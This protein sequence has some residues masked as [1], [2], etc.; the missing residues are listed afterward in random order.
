MFDCHPSAE[1]LK[2]GFLEL[3]YFQDKRDDKSH[4][5]HGRYTGL[6]Q[7]YISRISEKASV[8]AEIKMSSEQIK[9][10]FLKWFAESYPSVKPGNH[11]I[12][13]H[14][15]FA[16]HVIGFLRGGNAASIEEGGNA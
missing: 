4:P 2:S 8:G 13:S 1:Q 11:S 7:E 3:L 6:Y 12:V 5:L 14:V 10:I 16:E 9:D 15:A